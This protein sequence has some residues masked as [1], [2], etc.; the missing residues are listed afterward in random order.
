MRTFAYLNMGSNNCDIDAD[1]QSSTNGCLSDVKV[2]AF[3][4]YTS[5]NRK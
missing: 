5:K 2:N 3:V 4:F 1:G